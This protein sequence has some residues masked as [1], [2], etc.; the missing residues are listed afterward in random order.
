MT[1]FRNDLNERKKG[2]KNI[3]LLIV[4]ILLIIGLV[5]AIVFA[6]SK[7]ISK[8]AEEVSNWQSKKTVVV[9]D[10]ELEAGEITSFTDS[11]DGYSKIEI[12]ADVLSLVVLEGSDFTIEYQGYRHLAPEYMIVDGTLFIEQHCENAKDFKDSAD[13][14]CKLTITLPS[15]STLESLNAELSVG[16]LE[17]YDIYIGEGSIKMD[18]GNVEFHDVDLLNTDITCDVGNI[19]INDGYV[20]YIDVIS[21]LGNIEI[22]VGDLSDYTIDAEVSL[23]A[24]TVNGTTMDNNYHQ[25]GDYGSIKAE[26]SLGN[27]EID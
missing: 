16:N 2:G 19:E 8:G 26:A 11:I 9:S 13:D 25:D 10:E 3:A 20:N 14:E 27:I 4:L 24:L 7:A 22:H 1:D 23:G 5:L 15:S 18:V 21:K 6:V 17:V 12:T